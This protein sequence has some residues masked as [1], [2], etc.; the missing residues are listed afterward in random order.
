MAG[1]KDLILRPIPRAEANACIRRLHYSHKIVANSQLHIGVFWQGRLEGAIQFGPSLDKRKLLGLVEGTG[2]NEFLELNRVAFSERLPRNSESRALAIACRLLR[3]HAPQVKWF[4]TFADG[5][6][7]GDGTIYRA[8]GFL[9]TLIK[10]NTTIWELHETRFVNVSQRTSNVERLRLNKVSMTKGKYIL[11]DGG[12]SMRALREAG[13]RP[14]PG[15]QLRYI[16]FLDESWR[17]RLT[18]PVLPYAA[19]DAAGARMFRGRSTAGGAAVPTAGGGS[20]P[21]RPLQSSEP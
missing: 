16:K 14:L 8:A 15:F 5:T 1:A 20:T 21:T 18:V 10:P 9:L 7:C 19:I 2:W 13:A 12:A 3:Q 11:D 6:Q 17:D 4:V